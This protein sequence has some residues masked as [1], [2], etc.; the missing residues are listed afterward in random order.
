MGEMGLS[1]TQTALWQGGGV[2]NYRLCRGRDSHSVS[3]EMMSEGAEL[4][5]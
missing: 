5:L 1:L 2:M 3:K 4:S